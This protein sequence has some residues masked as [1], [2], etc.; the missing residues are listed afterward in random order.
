MYHLYLDSM[1]VSKKCRCF[2]DVVRQ[3]RKYF[4]TMSWLFHWTYLI[5][6][7]S[8]GLNT[9]DRQVFQQDVAIDW[10]SWRLTPEC[11]CGKSFSDN[12]GKHCHRCGQMYC[13][14]CI[15]HRQPIPGHFSQRPVP[16]C[17]ACHDS[18]YR[19]I[20]DDK[21]IMR[22][23]VLELKIWKFSLQVHSAW[24]F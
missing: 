17:N 15:V 14:R 9:I 20:N 3:L 11:V 23:F 16:L 10:A 6:L 1:H 19:W 8:L 24:V 18:W 22:Q 5:L 21:S 4:R 7:H 2:F 13:V 12:K